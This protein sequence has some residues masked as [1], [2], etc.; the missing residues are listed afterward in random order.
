MPL[1]ASKY[2]RNVNHF[3]TGI[4]SV[5]V[6]LSSKRVNGMCM[7]LFLGAFFNQTQFWAITQEDLQGLIINYYILRSA[8]W[9]QSTY[10]NSF[11]L[12]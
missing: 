4:K 2:F 10:I 6:S 7:T 1:L 11:N 3:G 12:H 9:K 5:N 8:G